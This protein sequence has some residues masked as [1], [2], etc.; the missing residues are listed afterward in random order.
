MNIVVTIKQVEDP[1]TPPAY[2]VLDASGKRA[3]SAS[4]TPLVMNGYDANALEEAL[5]LKERHGGKITAICVAD[6]SGRKTLKRA[7][8]MGADSA[9]LLSDPLWQT[10]DSCGIACVLAAAVRKIGQVDLVF[11]GRQASDSDNGQVYTGWPSC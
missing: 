6:D 8:A 7:V 1:I 9:I 4:G 5:R 3:V 2:L 10:L 11:C